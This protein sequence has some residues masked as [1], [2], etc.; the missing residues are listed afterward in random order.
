MT[1]PK[2][3]CILHKYISNTEDKD[4]GNTIFEYVTIINPVGENVTAVRTPIGTLCWISEEHIEMFHNDLKA[5]VNK[6]RI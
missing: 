4:I 3:S 1:T 2:Y 5:I 6:Y